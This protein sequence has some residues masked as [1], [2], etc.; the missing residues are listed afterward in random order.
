MKRLLSPLVQE[1]S[2]TWGREPS[3]TNSAVGSDCSKSSGREKTGLL[4]KRGRGGREGGRKG[5]GGGEIIRAKK[6]HVRTKIYSD[7]WIENLIKKRF[8]STENWIVA[9]RITDRGIISSTKQKYIEMEIMTE[10]IRYVAEKPRDQIWS[11]QG[12]KMTH[13]HFQLN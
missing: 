3:W 4:T 13:W 10:E 9:M 7:S 11:G 5:A 6:R 1:D 12:M 8:F 2:E